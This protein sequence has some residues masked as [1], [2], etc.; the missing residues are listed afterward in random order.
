MMDTFLHTIIYIELENGSCLLKSVNFTPLIIIKEKVTKITNERG[1][2]VENQVKC[3]LASIFKILQE[4]NPLIESNFEIETKYKILQAFKEIDIQSLD[5]IPK[6]YQDILLKKD[7]IQK[8]YQT[9]NTNL[10][11]MKRIIINLLK[12]VGKVVHVKDKEEKL[13]QLE[14][15]FKKY[16]VEKMVDLFKEFAKTNN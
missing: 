6:E 1:K 7:L 16:S 11:F 2:S 12:T 9:R 3:E 10:H 15:I 13:E 8:N 4:I 14:V 5:I